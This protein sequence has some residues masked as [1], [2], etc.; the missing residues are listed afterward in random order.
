MLV[1]RPREIV[2]DNGNLYVKDI[3]WSGWRSSAP[4]GSG[5]GVINNCQPACYDST[6]YSY[7]PA[8]IDLS[9]PVPDGQG[10]EAY[11][12]MSVTGLPGVGTFTGLAP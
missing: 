11:S 9:D 1:A 2:L 6:S 5:T 7:L 12:T 4:A 8:T 3:F 10:E